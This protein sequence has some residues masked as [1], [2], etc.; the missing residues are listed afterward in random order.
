VVA[1]DLAHVKQFFGFNDWPEGVAQIDLGDRI[2]DVLPT[3]GHYPSHVAYYD[4]NTAL[5][6]SGDFFMPARL[7]IDDTASDVASARRVANFIK[8]RPV[9]YVLGG[10]IELDANGQTFAW[11]STYHPNEHVLQLTK[12]DLLGLP[13]VVDTF[14]G[15]YTQNGMFVMFNQFRLLAAELAAVVLVLT[16]I[17]I[18]IWRYLRRR[19]RMR[20]MRA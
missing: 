11:G 2:V 3:P 20:L 7:I 8:E 16:A 18:S 14:N 6:F 9:S 4:R 1:T 12:L 10:H 5:L 19:K 13:A 17:A 15:F